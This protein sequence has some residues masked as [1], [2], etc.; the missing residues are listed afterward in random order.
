[1]KIRAYLSAALLGTASLCGHAGAAENGTGATVVNPGTVEHPSP[2]I[3]PGGV[4]ILRGGSPPSPNVG[5]PEANINLPVGAVFP[6]QGW[7]R[8]FDTNG[9]DRNYDTSG[10]DRGG[11]RRYDTTGFDR[12]FDRSGLSR[13]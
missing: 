10:I 3:A 6:T 9:I 11:V 12:N 5:P 2:E 8:Y 13:P 1:M 7:D 4:V